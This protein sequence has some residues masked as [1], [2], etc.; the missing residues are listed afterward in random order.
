MIE[1]MSVDF[2]AIEFKGEYALVAE[3]RV[4]KTAVPEGLYA[5]DMRHG[6]DWG[7]P[8]T[9]EKDVRVNFHGTIVFNHPIDIPEC[10]YISMNSY[11]DINYLGYCAR[12]ADPWGSEEQAIQPTM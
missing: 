2:E 7:E 11:E 3:Q 12:L 4:D 9:I 1:T 10:G 6:D 5:Y 8:I